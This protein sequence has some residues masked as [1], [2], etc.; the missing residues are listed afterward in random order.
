M[1]NLKETQAEILDVLLQKHKSG[2]LMWKARP[3]EDSFDTD[4][5]PFS[6]HVDRKTVAG[7]VSFKVWV[8]NVSSEV[9][10]SFD[11]KTLADLLPRDKQFE[12]YTKLA[13]YIYR[14][15]QNSLTVS[16]LTPVL[17]KLKS[18]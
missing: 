15:I 7:V 13:S 17:E 3:N 4:V 1:A 2:K 11:T 6:I 14:S 9:V 10:D 5:P 18:Q 16:A 8:F 12:N